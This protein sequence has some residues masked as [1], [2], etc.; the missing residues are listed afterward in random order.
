MDCELFEKP[1]VV[2]ESLHMDEEVHYDVLPGL[3]LDMY[4]FNKN[5]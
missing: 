4:I 1:T 2:V 5:C 3:L